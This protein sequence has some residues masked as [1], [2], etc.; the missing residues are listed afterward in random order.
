VLAGDFE[1]GAVLDLREIAT[2][3]AGESAPSENGSP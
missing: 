1:N 2:A 3:P